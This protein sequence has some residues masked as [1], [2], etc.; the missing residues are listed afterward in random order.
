M[1]IFCSSLYN[2]FRHVDTLQLKK[3]KEAQRP[4]VSQKIHHWSSLTWRTEREIA[5]NN[6]MLRLIGHLSCQ[7][8][9]EGQREDWVPLGGRIGSESSPFV[10]KTPSNS[11]SIPHIIMLPSLVREKQINVIWP[12]RSRILSLRFCDYLWQ[13]WNIL[14]WFDMII[15][16]KQYDVNVADLMTNNPVYTVYT[17]NSSTHSYS[18]QICSGSGFGDIKERVRLCGMF[19]L[20]I[21]THRKCF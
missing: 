19:D 6:N 4:S 10:S 8:L 20:I 2:C 14:S 21:C 5:Y 18:T 17:F 16:P 11:Y 9:N 3:E 13:L 12:T 15:I 1:W 7:L